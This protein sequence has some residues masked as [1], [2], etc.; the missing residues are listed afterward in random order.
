MRPPPAVVFTITRNTKFGPSMLAEATQLGVAIWAQAV[1][2]D[3]TTPNDPDP[4]LFIGPLVPMNPEVYG[5]AVPIQSDPSG[6]GSKV[7]RF[8]RESRSV[9]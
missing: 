2:E 9:I 4:D 3:A 6:M 7:P 5:T 8:V 1:F